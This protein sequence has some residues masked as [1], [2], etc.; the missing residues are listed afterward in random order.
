MNDTAKLAGFFAAHAIWSVSDGETLV[1]LL[2]FAKFDGVR[3]MARLEG[4]DM[5]EA[6]EAGRNWLANNPDAAQRAVLIYDGYVTRESGEKTDG[7]IIE[8]REYGEQP[9]SFTMTVPYRNAAHAEGFLVYRPAV[10]SLSDADV[11]IADISQAFFR[12]VN[13]HRQAAPVW[14]RHFNPEA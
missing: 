7:L 13:Q 10:E 9:R 12:G 11:S 6:I 14:A 4:A 8:A 1:P 3:E 2:A 5:A